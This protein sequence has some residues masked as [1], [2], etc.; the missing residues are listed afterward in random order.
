M[1][2]AMAAALVA[3][4]VGLSE[5]DRRVSCNVGGAGRSSRLRPSRRPTSSEAAPISL[6][7]T[8]SRSQPNPACTLNSGS[9]GI[10]QGSHQRP[11]SRDEQWDKFADCLGAQFQDAEKSRAFETLMMFDRLNGAGELGLQRH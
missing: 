1:Q 6:P 7:P 4:K 5:S 8:R 9:G 3:R 10:C 2:F 11:L